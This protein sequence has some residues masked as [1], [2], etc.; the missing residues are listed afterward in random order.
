MFFIQT[1][2]PTSRM[3]QNFT[4]QENKQLPTEIPIEIND[5][6]NIYPN[7]C[8]WSISFLSISSDVINIDM[9]L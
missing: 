4:K 1:T 5:N 6:S 8:F 7:M 2:T 3:H 9:P